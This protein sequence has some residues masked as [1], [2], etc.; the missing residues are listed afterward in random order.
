[1]K[2]EDQYVLAS[3]ICDV[4]GMVLLTLS[5]IK[6]FDPIIFVSGCM[7]FWFAGMFNG[8]RFSIE[9]NKKERSR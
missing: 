4:V 2:T 7:I 6:P 8:M 5:A 3:I 9:K 1:M